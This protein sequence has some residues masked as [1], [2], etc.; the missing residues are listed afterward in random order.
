MDGA[1]YFSIG[2]Y[3]KSSQMPQQ[4]VQSILS[5][6]KSLK[7]RILW[8]WEDDKVLILFNNFFNFLQFFNIF[9]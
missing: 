6:F 3:M 5:V 8:K 2:A 1:I 4:K 9:Y 7:Q